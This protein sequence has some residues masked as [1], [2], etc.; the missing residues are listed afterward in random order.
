MFIVKYYALVSI[1][2][3]SVGIFVESIYFKAILFWISA[4]FGIVTIAYIFD[5]P[6]VFRKNID[7]RIPWYIKW[8][9]MPFF[10]SAQIYNAWSRKTDSVPILQEITS[11]LFL[12]CRLFPSDVEALK[13]KDISAIFDATSEF[14]GL[15]SSSAWEGM[16]YYNL[17]ILDHKAPH[18]SD[19][20]H[21]LY[22]I[23]NQISSGN[24]VVVHCALGRGRSV[25]IVAAYLLAKSHASSVDEALSIISSIRETARLN[26]FQDKKL[27]RMLQDDQLK[28]KKHM[29]L[30]ANPKAGGGKWVENKEHI[31]ASLSPHFMLHIEE[32]EADTDVTALVEKRIKEKAD[33]VVACGGD[34]TVNQVAQALENTNTTLGI[35]PCGTTNALAHVLLGFST[36]FDGINIACDALIN[37]NKKAMDVM[38]CNDELSILAI[39]LGFE[40]QMIEKANREEKDSH[41]ELAYL[42]GMKEAIEENSPIKMKIII[43][44][45]E[46]S[47]EEFSS[48]VIA[49]AAPSTTVLAQGNG[50]PD[51]FDN[52]MDVTLLLHNETPIKSVASMGGK[53]LDLDFESDIED[54]CE[55]WYATHVLLQTDSD[56]KIKYSIDG[57]LRESQ[58]VDIR[59][60]AKAVNIVVAEDI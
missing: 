51:P 47:H 46:V 30:I 48:L 45:N 24:K 20:Q 42:H 33:I 18:K 57:E 32:T 50:K 6:K 22:W 19:I 56:Q 23:D 40:Q 1:L 55:H 31:L 14:D 27:N 3:F 17:P 37:G 21:A 60:N 9:M 10:L 36:K 39:G 38:H 29:T 5:I 11:D 12:A 2:F 53:A 44:D 13:E 16:H 41:G 15:G 26:K 49:N 54:A 4:S 7:G 58:K 52:K 43:D 59:I 28:L 25:L 34:G 35:I 8:L